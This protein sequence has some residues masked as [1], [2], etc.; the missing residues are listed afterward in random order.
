MNVTSTN[1]RSPLNTQLTITRI[2]LTGYVLKS[3]VTE[4]LALAVTASSGYIF[5]GKDGSW[6]TNAGKCATTTAGGVTTI[7]LPA[8]LTINALGTYAGSGGACLYTATK[9][10]LFA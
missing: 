8:P 2:V 5:M 4:G 10:E 7:T 3:T 6:N 9:L 1:Y